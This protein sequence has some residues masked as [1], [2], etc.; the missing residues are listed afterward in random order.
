MNRP[1]TANK[2]PKHEL[3]PPIS[4]KFSKA[5]ILE[6]H[7]EHLECRVCQKIWHTS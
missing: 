3:P 5:E 7:F 6:V 4:Q 1:K 2:Q